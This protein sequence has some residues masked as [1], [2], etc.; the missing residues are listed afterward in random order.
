M[1]QEAFVCDTCGERHEGLPTDFGFRLPDE[2]HALSYLDRYLR[3]RYN[4]DLCTLD[5][6]RYFVRGVLRVPLLEAR[7]DFGWGVWVEV[8]AADHDNYVRRFHDAA[9]NAPRFPGVLANAIPGHE[10]ALGLP[11]EVQLGREDQR[12]M[13]HCLAASTHALAIEQREGISAR[14]HHAI[15]ECTGFFQHDG[16][17]A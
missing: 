7:E 14:R 13:L 10:R 16:D 2:V 9:E 11:L 5:E 17:G 1:N 6:S 8:S 12:P 4:A 3:S 15:L